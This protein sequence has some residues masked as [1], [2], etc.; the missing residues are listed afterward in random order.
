VLTE[1]CKYARFRNNTSVRK[2]ADRGRKGASRSS[3]NIA[4]SQLTES[5]IHPATAS[6]SKLCELGSLVLTSWPETMAREEKSGVEKMKNT[7][8]VRP[9][10][11]LGG[12][13]GQCPRGRLDATR[14]SLH[15]GT[16]G[17]TAS[18]ASTGVHTHTWTTAS[19]HSMPSEEVR[20]DVKSA[21]TERRFSE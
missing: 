6:L 16:T 3:H 18:G 5:K 7:L 15:R 17:S 2:C 10:A 12:M 13:A 20:R 11:C 19:T 14:G 4:Q 1:S 21:A 8:T 9:G